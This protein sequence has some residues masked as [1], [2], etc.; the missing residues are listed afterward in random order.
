VEYVV[1]PGDSLWK[2]C[3]K[4]GL[5]DPYRVARENGTADPDRI[6][7]GQRLV[8]HPR[9]SQG[10]QQ[11]WEMVAPWYGAEHQH[12]RTASGE[13]F[14]MTKNTLA[15]KSLPFGTRV[16][17]TNPESGRVAEGVVNDRGPYLKGRDLDVSYALAKEL[18]FLRKG[19]TKLL[20]EIL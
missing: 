5:P 18:G 19:V 2:I 7:P 3:K 17:L 13:R 8:L 10:S 20:V 1:Q 11:G 4:M 16:R 6:R 9:P 15:H 14:D 12:K